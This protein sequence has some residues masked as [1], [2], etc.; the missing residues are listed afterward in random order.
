MMNRFF[1][2]LFAASCLT[3]VGQKL[4]VGKLIEADFSKGEDVAWVD[5]C[6]ESMDLSKSKRAEF[7]AKYRKMESDISAEKRK[8]RSHEMSLL[9]PFMTSEKAV[10]QAIEAI[11]KVKS[12]MISI[13]RDFMTKLV[14][15]LGPKSAIEFNLIERE[16]KRQLKAHRRQQE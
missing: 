10:T 8:K 15:M 12:E 13:E 11:A 3:A 14:K 7:W 4:P 5:F 9:N 1:T 6:N 2:L 16:Y